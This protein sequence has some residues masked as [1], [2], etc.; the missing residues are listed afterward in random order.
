MNDEWDELVTK[1][2]RK[3][4]GPMIPSQRID[5]TEGASSGHVPTDMPDA[6]SPDHAAPP[7]VVSISSPEKPRAH[8]TRASKGI[9]LFLTSCVAILVVYGS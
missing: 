6:P 4:G 1:F 2:L 5:T 3:A 8:L 9:L 7:L